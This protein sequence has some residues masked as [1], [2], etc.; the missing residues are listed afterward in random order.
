[1]GIESREYLRDEGDVSFGGQRSVQP[2]SVVTK[3]I[4]ATVAVFVLQLLS[5]N[6]A[7]GTSGLEPWFILS[8][9]KLFHG[10][11]WRLL[12]Y[13]FLHDTGFLLHIV[14]N[15]YMLHVLGRATAQLTGNREFLWFYAASAMF[16]GLCSVCFYRLLQVN[17]NI[18]G[19]S[20][21][22]F[23]VFTLFAMHYP[24]QKLYLFAILGIEVRWLLVI[25]VVIEA[26]P[27]VRQLVDGQLGN[28]GTAHS[29]HLGGLLFGWLYFR[30][31]M[32]FSTWW[33][34]VA[35]RTSTRIKAGKSGLRV[36]N[37]KNQ[38]ESNLSDRVDA[39]LAKISSQGEEALTERERRILRQA[40]E[41]MKKRR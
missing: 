8:G 11:I 21:A 20:G 1:M 4:L 28:D 26:H 6:S 18:L 16:S 10:Q 9:S 41:Q 7:D 5:T 36:Y 34:R 30:W 22:V 33:D 27:V 2:M 29:A 40:S 35:R 12:S 17:P 24:R 32:R 3:I 13:A 37:P 23:A 31:N 15:M 19:A 39:I 14:L 25:Y 38:P